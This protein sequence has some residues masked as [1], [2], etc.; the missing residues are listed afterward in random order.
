MNLIYFYV[1][2]IIRGDQMNILLKCFKNVQSIDT[3][4]RKSLRKKKKLNYTL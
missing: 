4:A 2:K 3:K 1:M